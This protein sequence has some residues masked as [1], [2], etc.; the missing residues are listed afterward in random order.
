LEQSQERVVGPQCVAEQQLLTP[1]EENQPPSLEPNPE[2]AEALDQLDWQDVFSS[3]PAGWA[4]SDDR[5]GLTCPQGYPLQLARLGHEQDGRKPRLFF[6]AS[7]KCCS[8]CEERTQ[9]AN[10]TSRRF[11]KFVTKTV[12]A[13]LAPKLESLIAQERKRR[14]LAK[15]PARSTTLVAARPTVRPKVVPVRFS[16][17][18]NDAPAGPWAV[19]GPLLLVAQLRRALVRACEDIEV[20]VKV[21]LAPTTLAPTWPAIARSAGHRQRRRQSFAQRN[22]RNRLPASAEVTICFGDNHDVLARLGCVR[23]GNH[24]N[25][26][27]A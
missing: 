19:T 2:L 26:K 25:Q 18:A 4:R 11:A 9:C 6:R 27:A 3:L 20:A 5:L 10:A 1:G 24:G 12:E 13:E 7:K 15:R 8:R 21:K 22:Q 23:V 17:A 16:P 14:Q